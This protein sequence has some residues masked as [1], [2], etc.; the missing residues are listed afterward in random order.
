MRKNTLKIK[1]SL[2]YGI[3]LFRANDILREI[4]FEPKILESCQKHLKKASWT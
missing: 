3:F 4:K 2:E 1:T